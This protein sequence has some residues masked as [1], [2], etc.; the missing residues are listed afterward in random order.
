MNKEDIKEHWKYTLG[1]IE[2]LPIEGNA[3]ID[4]YQKWVPLLEYLYIEAMLHGYKHGLQ[5]LEETSNG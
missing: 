5:T 3:T 4:E 2:R 1:V